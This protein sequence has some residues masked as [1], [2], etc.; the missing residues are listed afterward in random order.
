MVE[1]IPETAQLIASGSCI[2]G[3]EL[4]S[5][6]IKACLTAPDGRPL[7]TGGHTWENRLV[8]GHWTYAL[9]AIW[10]GIAAA[11]ADLSAQTTARYGAAPTRLHAMGVSAMMHGY[12]AF[13]AQ[14]ELLVPFRTWRDTTTARAAGELTSVLGVNIPLRWSVAHYYQAVL[15]AEPHVPQVDFL[16]TLS[17]YVHW[18]LTGEK[19]LGIGDASGMFP[20]DSTSCDY[21]RGM[22]DAF[23]AHIRALVPESDLSRL[24]P[25]VLTAGTPA[26]T[27]SAAGALLLDPTGALQPGTALCPPEG[28]AGTGMVATDSVRPR[29]GNVSVGTSIFAMVVLEKP[30]REIHHEIDLVTTPAGEAVAMVHC[31][32]GADELS[33]WVA[34]FVQAARLFAPETEIDPDT[35][36]AELLAA[37]LRAQ[38]DAGGL[39][40]YNYIS[41]EPITGQA[42][43]RP[44]MV[45]GPE[46]ALN[47]ENIMRSQMFSV[48]A[49]LAIGLD[50]L[51]AEDVALDF[52]NAHGGLLKTADVAAR[53][54]AAAAGTP[55][56]VT[57]GAGEGGAWGIALLAA[58]LDHAQAPLHTF[59]ANTVFADAP[60]QTVRPEPVDANGFRRFLDH[61]RRGLDLQATAVAATDRTAH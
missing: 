29:T 8:D 5:T 14:G 19:V 59:L 34:L 20:I 15:D 39:L 4:G 37:A 52:L 43:G 24:L 12:L 17:G 18:R 49:T 6:R 47:L 44:L 16:T 55:I 40:S 42:D 61:Y 58:Y 27:L 50:V 54:L 57:E 26:G 56:V 3:L 22:L 23:D 9:D 36:Y 28:D 13:D 21:D 2:L 32:N 48:F 46:T 45:R 1:N 10:E 51:R 30:L 31:N 35:A 41:G 38:P 25:R 53:L 60:A 7:A 11:Y 33:R